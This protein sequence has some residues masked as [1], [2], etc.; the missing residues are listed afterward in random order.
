MAL[1]TLNVTPGSGA[2]INT[3]PNAPATTANSVSVALATDQTAV[4][5]NLTQVGGAAAATAGAGILKVGAVGATGTVLDAAPGTS[6]AGARAVQGVNGGVPVTTQVDPTAAAY[7]NVSGYL[8]GTVSGAAVTA[9]GTGGGWVP[10]ASSIT[11]HSTGSGVTT[12]GVLGVATTQIIGAPT[13]AA[14]GTFTGTTG[15]YNVTG[16]TGTGTK[17]SVAVTLTNGSGI[18]AVGGIVSGGSYTVNPTT[19][20]NEPVAWTGL[21]GGA[22]SITM[23]IGTLSVTSGGAYAPTTAAQIT[24]LT[25]AVTPASV[26]GGG[27]LTGVT[28]APSFNGVAT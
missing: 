20:T 25:G 16:T 10:G 18:T 22:L 2:T 17:F 3:L 21:T 11:L 5:N 13:I 6:A 7:T 15:V 12:S 27:S 26:S 1:P 9:V 8:Q 14:A 4:P 23:G 24:T 28:I 19:L